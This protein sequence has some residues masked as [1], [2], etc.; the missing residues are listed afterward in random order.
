MDILSIV[1][2]GTGLAMDCFAV[3]ISKGIRVKKHVFWLTFRMAFLFG[4]FQAMMPL[5]GYLA[6]ASFVVYMKNI[7]HWIAFGLLTLIGGKMIF[8]G[9][10]PIDPDSDKVVYPFA[11]A[12]ILSL[13]LATSIDAFATG[14]VFVPYPH[15]IW[16][17]IL[18][19]GII[20]FIFTFLGVYIGV[21][22]GK[23]FHLKVEMI[24]GFILVGI[25]FKILID[26]LFNLG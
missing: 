20:S 19:I 15:L 11:W 7:D 17:A 16:R 13:A 21:H 25:G 5:I 6:G 8:E 23:R 2:I 12:S 9:Y 1:I 10:K 22:F 14:I 26:H 18:I 24:G 3:S 4:L